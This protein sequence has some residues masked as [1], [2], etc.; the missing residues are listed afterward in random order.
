MVQNRVS[1]HK[2]YLYLQ[3]SLLCRN[4]FSSTFPY[5]KKQAECRRKVWKA[6]TDSHGFE[7]DVFS[8][9]SLN[10]KESHLGEGERKRA[11]Y[12]VREGML[13]VWKDKKW[14]FKN[15]NK[16]GWRREQKAVFLTHINRSVLRATFCSPFKMLNLCQ[17]CLH[18][19]SPPVP[20]PSLKL[21]EWFKQG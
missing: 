11:T 3:N 10:K 9:L 12:T 6:C 1:A 15:L 4:H 18:S 17:S 19:F 7:R 13:H 14:T 16:W 20:L 2:L 8:L 21:L 5:V